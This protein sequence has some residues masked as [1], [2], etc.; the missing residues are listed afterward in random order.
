VSNNHHSHFE[1]KT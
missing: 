1:T